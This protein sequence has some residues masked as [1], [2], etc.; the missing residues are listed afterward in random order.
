MHLFC[1][2]LWLRFLKLCCEK[3]V[4]G[5]LK[6][7][8]MVAWLSG[9]FSAHCMPDVII[10]HQRQN[11]PVRPVLLKCRRSLLPAG[12]LVLGFFFSFS[13]DTP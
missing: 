12:S 4:I 5:L 3:V 13:P 6:F 1:D 2:G 8:L 7:N 10:F 9:S 11:K